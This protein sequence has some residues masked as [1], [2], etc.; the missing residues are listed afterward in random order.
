[1]PDFILS[2]LI[3]TIVGREK[4]YEHLISRLQAQCS[5]YNDIEI[6]F[7]KDNK[8]MPLGQKRN[9]LYKSANGVYSWML[10]DDDDIA[11]NAIDL[12]YPNLFHNADCI[13]FLEHVNFNGEERISWHSNRFAD[14]GN[15]YTEDGKYYH[16]IRTPYYKDVI[17]TSICKSVPIKEIRYAEDIQ[18]SRDLKKASAIKT[19]IFIPELIYYYSY[20]PM[21]ESELK[22]RY[23]IK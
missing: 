19:E 11:D 20:M 4:E 1:M 6:L 5:K 16:Y 7:A 9:E 2:I 15:D 17:K 12:I 14:W 10:D 21:N 8:E 13:T 23:G 3:P 18:W 22:K